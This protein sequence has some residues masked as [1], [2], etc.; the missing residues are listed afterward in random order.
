MGN[1]AK[2][3][4]K[5]IQ[6]CLLIKQEVYLV[7]LRSSSVSLS[8]TRALWRTRAHVVRHD[9]AGGHVVSLHVDHQKVVPLP[10]GINHYKVRTQTQNLT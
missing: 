4:H 3:G 2:H 10:S 7:K 8:L 1:F 6:S 9:A 5:S